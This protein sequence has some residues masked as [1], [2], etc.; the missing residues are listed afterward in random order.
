MKILDNELD[1]LTYFD[2]NNIINDYLG[3]GKNIDIEEK[4]LEDENELK[5]L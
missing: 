1:L 5:K 2:K 3:S 4:D